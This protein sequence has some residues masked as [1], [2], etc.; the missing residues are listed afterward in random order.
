MPLGPG[1]NP[2]LVSARENLRNTPMG[3]RRWEATLAV[4]ITALALTACTST[5]DA[6]IEQ[7]FPQAYAEGYDAGCAS[8]KAAAGSTFHS[9]RKDDRRYAADSQYAQGWDAGFAKC[10]RDMAAMVLDARR[11]RPGN[12]GQARLRRAIRRTRG[13]VGGHTPGCPPPGCNTRSPLWPR[14]LRSSPAPRPRTR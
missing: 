2:V 14:R 7:G 8:G 4:L 13:G 3:A 5:R 9:A 12:G 11:R 10:E 1:L 6:L